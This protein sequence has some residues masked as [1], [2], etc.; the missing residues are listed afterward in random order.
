MDQLFKVLC[1]NSYIPK[2]TCVQLEDFVDFEE[3]ETDSIQM[4]LDDDGAANI[5]SETFGEFTVKT[6][7][8]FI[9]ENKCK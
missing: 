2:E 1:G 5:S 7:K 8:T 9:Q 4:D 3:Y 6:M